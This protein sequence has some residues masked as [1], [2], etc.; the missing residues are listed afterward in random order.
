MA[1]DGRLTPRGGR[2]LCAGMPFDAVRALHEVLGILLPVHDILDE[3]ADSGEPPA[4]CER[5]GW[6]AFLMGLGEAELRRCEAEGFAARALMLTD[7]PASLAALAASV[8]EKTQLPMVGDVGGGGVARMGGATSGGVAI[9]PGALRAVPE[10]KRHQLAALLGAVETMAEHAGRIVDVG[11][12]SGHFTR[13]AAARFERETVGI[14]RNAERVAAAEARAEEH[15]GQGESGPA[16]ARFVEVDACREALAFEAADLAV[17]LHACGGLGDRLVQSA[18]EA[19]CDVALVSCCLQKIET[20]ARAP[21][22]RAGAGFALRRETLGLTNLTSQP[23]GVETTIEATIAARQARHALIHLLRARGLEVAPGEEMRGINRRRAHAGLADI[24]ARAL[25][26]RGLAA[27]TPAEIHHHEQ[28][29]H[30]RYAVVRRTSLPRNMLARLVEIAVV[31]DRAAALTESGH[32][33]RIAT[34]FDR[35]VT[36][37]NLALFASREPSRLPAEIG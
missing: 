9:A 37:R 2:S 11:A 18:A 29:A 27:P 34:L 14:E 4:W 15:V 8:V 7:V 35:S 19:G 10:R 13:L 33:A 26:L 25:A 6:T 16:R 20:S 28:A 22:S 5:R 12:G 36:P 17:G 23:R 3:R 30:G 31:L 32:H 24:A 1:Q 21:L